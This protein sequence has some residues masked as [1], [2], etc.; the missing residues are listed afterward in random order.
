MRP[1]ILSVLW[2]AVVGC[3]SRQTT[4]QPEQTQSAIISTIELKEDLSASDF[5]AAIVGKWRSMFTYK[6]KRNVQNLEFT[7]D[8]AASILIRQD[9]KT[10]SR[11]GPYTV[12]LELRQTSGTV[13]SAT[14]TIRPKHSLQIVL[15][16][17]HFGLHNGVNIKE[18]PLLR[19][20]GEPRG[21]LKR[22]N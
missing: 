17:V 7:S 22:K 9:D 8:G 16:R 13:K 6:N 18:G 3:A 20:D 19:I 5:N 11:S 21:V 15:S 4:V 14:I 12:E 1:L 2:I 10:T